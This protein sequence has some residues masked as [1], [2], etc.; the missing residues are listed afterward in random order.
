MTLRE[1]LEG[2]VFMIAQALVASGKHTNRYELAR[3][4]VL[5]AVAVKD[6]VEEFVLGSKPAQDEPHKS[7]QKASYMAH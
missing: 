1:E 2:Q 6:E 7:V 4:A 5:V 3:E